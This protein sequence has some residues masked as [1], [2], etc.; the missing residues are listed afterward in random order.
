MHGEAQILTHARQPHVLQL[1]E[2]DAVQCAED[3]FAADAPGILGDQAQK[4]VGLR[5]IPG[6]VDEQR[7][8]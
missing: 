8:V 6:R 2:F 3:W 4:A 5:F 7:L 1:H